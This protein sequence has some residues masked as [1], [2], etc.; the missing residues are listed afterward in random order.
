MVPDVSSLGASGTVASRVD[1]PGLARE[2]TMTKR[3][4]LYARV[5]TDDQSDKGYSLPSQLEAM[6]KYATQ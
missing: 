4:V 6:R 5:S 3:A 1:N 2:H